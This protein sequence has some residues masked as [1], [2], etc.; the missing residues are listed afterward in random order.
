LLS[1]KTLQLLK[2]QV[3]FHQL[4]KFVVFGAYAHL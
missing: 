2:C 4:L 3:F 1:I